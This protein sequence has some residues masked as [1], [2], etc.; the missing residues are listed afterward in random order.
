M[1]YHKLGNI[2]LR[3]LI[4]LGVGLSGVS[5]MDRFIYDYEGD[6]DDTVEIFLKYDY[7]T[8]RADMR[9]YHVGYAVVYALDENGV[10]AARQNVGKTQ[11]S[12]K[13][14]TVV[15]RGLKP[16]K[17]TFRAFAMQQPFESQAAL[18]GSRFRVSFPGE[19]ETLGD[20]KIKLDRHN[21]IIEAPSN[22]LDTLWVGKNISP[23]GV[24][25]PDVDN[26]FGRVHRDTVSLVRDTKY[27][28]LTLNQIEEGKRAEINDRDFIVRIVDDNGIVAYDNSLLSDETLEYKPFATWTTSL[29]EKGVAYDS[30]EAEKAAPATDPIVERAAHY[31]ISCSR[32]MYYATASQGTNARLQIVRVEDEETVVDINLPYYLSFGRD[33]YSVLNYSRQEYLDREYDY[34]LDFFLQDGKWK[35]LYLRINI[36]NWSKRIQNEVL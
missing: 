34:H 12:D 3:S 5:C 25:M 18:A 16:G 14:S 35:E 4:M 1:I 24:T 10:V 23:E 6:C 13:N 8:Q 9:P 33:Y 11:L 22:G 36:A 21:S 30:E 20:L 27:I 29:S 32:L 31:N 28:H 2:L 15:F 17:Y 19:G 26:Q 7:N